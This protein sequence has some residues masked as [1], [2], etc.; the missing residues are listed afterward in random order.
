MGLPP[1]ST[2][3]PYTTLFRSGTSNPASGWARSPSR[4]QIPIPQPYHTRSRSEEH[5]SELQ[6]LRHLVCRLLLE[7]WGYHRDL[8]S[9]PT[10]RSSDLAHRTPPAG[11]RARPPEDKFPSRSRTTLAPDRK[12]T[13]LN[14]SHLGIS[15]AVFC[16]KDGATTEIYTLSLHDA[17]PIWHIEPRQR[18]GA[19]ALQ[20]T[21]S[22]PAAVP[23]SLR[24][25]DG[26][27]VDLL[28]AVAPAGNRIQPK[29][30]LSAPTGGR[31][32]Q[33]APA[34]SD[35][36][37]AARIRTDG[38]HTASRTGSYC[39]E[40]IPLQPRQ[41]LGG[42]GPDL[43]LRRLVQN[44]NLHRG[45]PLLL[46]IGAKLPAIVTE[47]TVL[48]AHPKESRT[49]LHQAVN[50]QVGQPRILSVLLKTVALPGHC[51]NQEQDQHRGA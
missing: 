26:N 14:S 9:F 10:R 1:R 16:L 37:I 49:V 40:I 13:R 19:L 44:R 51:P 35:V 42:P 22:H 4:R 24:R 20:K 48:R 7:R 34:G 12:S 23:H 50:I 29:L 15:Y 46:G 32:R 6:S 39:L 3:F 11:G 30:A 2:L 47:Q 25:L 5:T 31:R 28:R 18:V 43:S 36:E 41:P 21:N 17:L 45:Q 33:Q 38:E 8:H 27:P